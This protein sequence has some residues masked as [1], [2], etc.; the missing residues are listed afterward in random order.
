MQ[1]FL[2]LRIRSLAARVAALEATV[3]GPHPR[4]VPSGRKG[5]WA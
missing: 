5:N 4:R 2:P 3:H 1:P